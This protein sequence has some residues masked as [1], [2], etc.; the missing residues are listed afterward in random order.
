MTRRHF[1]NAERAALYIAAD[2]KCQSCGI[3]LD[4]TWEPDHVM[5]YSKGGDTDVLNGQALCRSCNRRKKDK[6]VFDKPLAVFRQWQ[7]EQQANFEQHDGKWFTLVATPGAGKTISMLRN[8]FYMLKSGNADFVIIV[9]PSETLKGQWKSKALNLFG[10]KLKSNFTGHISRDYD[11]IVVTY[12]QLAGSIGN[13]A[14]RNIHSYRGRVF[15]IFDEPHHMADGKAWGDSAR[16]ALGISASGGVLGTGTPFR[17]DDYPIPFVEYTRDTHTLI[18]HYQ[19]LYDDGLIDRVV[20]GI[21]FRKIDTQASW[22][23]YNDEIMTDISFYDELNDRQSQERLNATIHPNSEFVAHVLAQ[24]YAETMHIRRTEQP[25][26]KGLIICKSTSHAQS[27]ADKFFKINGVMPVVVSSDDEHGNNKDIENFRDSDDVFIVS[28]DMISEGVDIP[29]LRTLVY[30][31]NKTAPLYFY[32]AIGRVVRVERGYELA[33][34]YVYLPSDNRLL[35]LAQEIKQQ[36]NHVA[37]FLRD[38]EDTEHIPDKNGTPDT[39]PKPQRMFEVI[40]ALAIDD[41]GI[42]GN[43]EYGDNELEEARLWIKNNGLRIPIEEAAKI[44]RLNKLS[45]VQPEV[46]TPHVI[47]PEKVENDLRN[48]CNRLAFRLMKQR[49]GQAETNPKRIHSEW[50]FNHSGQWQNMADIADL[51]RKARWLKSELGLQDDAD[52]AG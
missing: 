12:Q 42:Y 23:S 29:P 13:E 38:S 4:D 20:R 11:G 48:L 5:P 6:I 14:I 33:N 37:K 46:K 26:A 15:T 52:V 28:V 24:A 19:Y 22:Y 47:D 17:S 45:A 10:I 49:Y 41:G 36:R 31:T 51:K 34:G 30:L 35:A 25:N 1:N 21:F 16:Y 39:T 40:N 18:P 43:D 50:V 27:I 8:A 9:V 44:L 7:D 3:E 32:Q 2:G